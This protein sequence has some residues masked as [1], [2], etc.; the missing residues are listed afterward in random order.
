MKYRKLTGLNGFT[1]IELL[2]S[3]GIISLLMTLLITNFD[4]LTAGN[5]LANDV[6]IFRSKLAAT[7]ILAGS[8][9]I[10]DDPGTG[11]VDQVGYYGLYLPNSGEYYYLLRLPASANPSEVIVPD[12]CSTKESETGFCLVESIR[13]SR[14]VHFSGPAAQQIIGYASPTQQL[15]K[16]LPPALSGDPWKPSSPDFSGFGF[17]L[18][19]QGRSAKV[20][21]DGYSGRVN[22]EYQN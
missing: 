20:S 7:R 17:T 11:G 8:T 14:N 21:L 2:I 6:E 22:V 13:F 4:R 12:N 9:Q 5:R 3:I 18:T 10:A 16:L 15:F 19:Y 1:L